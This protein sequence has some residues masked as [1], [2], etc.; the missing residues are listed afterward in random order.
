M[1]TLASVTATVPVFVAPPATVAPS[2][3]AL[4]AQLLA[5]ARTAE[6]KLKT[7]NEKAVV[8]LAIGKAQ[9]VLGQNAAA[10]DTLR[11]GEAASRSIVPEPSSTS[12]SVYSSS[13]QRAALPVV[14]VPLG[15]GYRIDSFGLGY[16]IAQMDAGAIDD[17][18]Q[19][20]LLTVKAEDKDDDADDEVVAAMEKRKPGS[21]K[22]VQ[23]WLAEYRAETRRALMQEVATGMREMLTKARADP[24]PYSR[25]AYLMSV[26]AYPYSPEMLALFSPEEKQAIWDDCVAGSR[27]ITDRKQRLQAL[28]S[29]G[30]LFPEREK[31]SVIVAEI[32]SLVPNDSDT[33]QGSPLATVQSH[34]QAFRTVLAD[35]ATPTETAITA[36]IAKQQA[37]FKRMME[38]GE[39]NHA[40]K[41]PEKLAAI[42]T[43]EAQ[44]LASK[45]VDG[46]ALRGVVMQYLQQD[47]VD[48][49]LRVAA[50]VPDG[51]RES[52]LDLIR[53]HKTPLTPPQRKAFLQIVLRWKN[54]KPSV[55]GD[56]PNSMDM[57][58]LL[59]FAG[60]DA[61]ARQVLR[62]LVT[63]LTTAPPNDFTSKEELW[64]SLLP[65]ARLQKECG[66]ATGAVSSLRQFCRLYDGED[67]EVFRDEQ[68]I[69]YLEEAAVLLIALKQP[70]AAQNVLRRPM[71][72]FVRR[73]Y[74]REEGAVM[75]N[76]RRR[77]QPPVLRDYS[78]VLLRYGAGAQARIGDLTGAA[79]TARSIRYPAYRAVT[80]AEV[81]HEYRIRNTDKRRKL[82]FINTSQSLS[83]ATPQPLHLGR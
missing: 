34:L 76:G 6:L 33:V 23:D 79:K 74:T 21:A 40:R 57:A 75:Y 51:W 63:F 73:P 47:A 1:V 50:G 56:A 9:T 53:Q 64:G 72:S 77:P 43:N 15:T 32:A 69:D 7:P 3:E 60:D 10:Q 48:D 66:D 31:L 20:A 4:L 35:T 11:R 83:L 45:P 12:F 82:P 81:V 38:E 22:P 65:A 30:Y 36:L 67:R 54:R 52:A 61:S 44:V 39:A 16:V 13:R 2:E 41:T 27:Q 78:P 18:V 80:L 17:A 49:A 46:N 71:E 37:Q 24:D 28:V 5:E 58:R 14:A 62:R 70:V 29:M 8:F 19:T 26:Y 68:Q 55:Y 42:R 59:H 25:V